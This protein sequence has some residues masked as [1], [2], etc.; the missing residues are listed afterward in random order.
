M[1]DSGEGIYRSA[2]KSTS[3]IGGSSF[4]S[5][6][7][8]MVRTKFAA[9]LLGPSGVGLIGVYSALMS[10]IGTLAGMGIATSGVRQ[11]AE[12]HG[13]A[14]H[15]QLARTVSIL[16]RT[17]WATGLMGMFAMIAGAHYL[18][19]L[20]F[21]DAEYAFTIALLGLG[22]LLGNIA[23][24]QA[25]ILQ[26]TRRIGALA[27]IG[28]LGAL[29]GTLLSVPCYHMWG[30]DGIVPGLLLTSVATLATTWW[31]ARRVSV[32][33]PALSGKDV[34]HGA[35]RLLHFGFP[36]MLSGLLM[37]L[38]AYACRIILLHMFGLDGVGIWHAAFSISGV[39]ASFVLQAMG[40]D[41]YPRLTA[42]IHDDARVDT[43]V[44]TQTEIAILLA[45]PGLMATL[46]FAPWAISLLY[47]AEF[48]SATG[49]LRWCIIGVF[50]RVISWPLGY[51]LLAKGMGK[52]YFLTELFANSFQV[53]TIWICSRV[54]GLE[55]TGVAFALLYLFYTP[56]IYGVARY[57]SRLRWSWEN[58]K[59]MLGLFLLL[60]V[61]GYIGHM[62]AN[63]WIRYPVNL[64]LLL[65]TGSYCLYRLA[66]GSRWSLLARFAKYGLLRPFVR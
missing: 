24:G 65:V 26:G 64:A 49:I 28:V 45:T 15:H 53:L 23:A 55:G 48:S 8:G 31:Y 58:K 7:I 25:C 57:V 61:S 9:V 50:G 3:L 60:G 44:N 22:I 11:I 27:K 54:W 51:V 19:R 38:S 34:I 47:T 56:F 36:V 1:A 41:Y 4:L 2:L 40:A 10:M 66:V 20:S 46:I 42:V 21:G 18:A 16:R 17:V 59:L 5:I 30:L 12:A 43:E 6:I 63:P 37:A 39:L 33:K 14:D 62:I 35:T 29:N 13:S 32:A 52:T